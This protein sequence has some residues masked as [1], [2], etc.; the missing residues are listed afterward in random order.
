MSIEN[1]ERQMIKTLLLE[2]AKE[3]EG[4]GVILE[5]CGT[6]KTLLDGMTT[7]D[8]GKGNIIYMLQY[9]VGVDTHSVMIQTAAKA[10]LVKK[11][12]FKEGVCG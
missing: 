11:P 5:P 9:N 1:L 8:M 12:I 10:E 7:E 4:V 3:R 2:M 6:G